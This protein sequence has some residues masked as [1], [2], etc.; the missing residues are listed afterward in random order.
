MILLFVLLSI[1]FVLMVLFFEVSFIWLICLLV[2]VILLIKFKFW[3]FVIRMLCENKS[4]L[5][6]LKN[7]ILVLF[8]F[9]MLIKMVLNVLVVVVVVVFGRK[10]LILVM[11]L[12]MVVNSCCGLKVWK[13]FG[14]LKSVGV[15]RLVLVLMRKLVFGVLNMVL[16]GELLLKKFGGKR[17]GLVNLLGMLFQLIL[18]CR[19]LKELLVLVIVLLLMVVWKVL[20]VVVIVVGLLFVVLK[21]ISDVQVVGV[22]RQVVMMLVSL[23][24][25]F[26]ICFF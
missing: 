18:W 8:D 2:L 20:C 17:L 26:I 13:L 6:L 21:V 9:L 23:Y 22:I 1:L 3:L 5:V 24:L 25:V 7:F 15:V 14:N 10:K 4:V 16:W 12:L 19:L 11:L